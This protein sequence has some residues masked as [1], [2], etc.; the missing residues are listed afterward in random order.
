MCAP[1][2]IV[3][4]LAQLLP[5]VSIVSLQGSSAWKQ[6]ICAYTTW[7][8]SSV[9]HGSLPTWQCDSSSLAKVTMHQT[10][11][12]LSFPI[13]SSSIWIVSARP[14]AYNAPLV[15]RFP[16]R[17]VSRHIGRDVLLPD[18]GIGGGPQC[19]FWCSQDRCY[20][21]AYTGMGCSTLKLQLSLLKHHYILSWLSTC[22]C[23]VSFVITQVVGRNFILFIIFGSL[24]EMHN[25][26][27]VFFVFYLW[28]S[29]EIVRW[30][31]A[32]TASS[33]VT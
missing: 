26:P 32:F 24:E 10:F 25:K 23:Y 2:V 28:S 7:Y 3:G 16:L 19:C 5:F 22:L 31:C 20:S 29:I 17:H 27:V 9:F 8:N 6:H 30:V 33:S 1:V 18:P 21:N 11:F 14:L 12:T 13:H 4:Q 15:F